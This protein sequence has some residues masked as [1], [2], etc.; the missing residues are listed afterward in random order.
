[1]DVKAETL[2]LVKKIKE[3]QEYID[4][5]NYRS[6]L[7]RHEELLCQV[8]E[9]RRKNFEIQVSHQYGAYNAYENLISLKQD[10]K[11]LLSEPKV[12]MFL[13]AELKLSK[14]MAS[15]YDTITEEIEFDTHF[16]E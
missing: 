1:M 3:K 11:E 9:F 13:D 10:Y 14:L 4:Y 6:I 2:E 15:V 12:K 5:L 16:L 7:E 8:E